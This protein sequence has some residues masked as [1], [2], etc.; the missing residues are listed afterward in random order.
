MALLLQLFSIL[1]FQ[2]LSLTYLRTPYDD[3][4]SISLRPWKRY[5]AQVGLAGHISGFSSF[6]IFREYSF[7]FS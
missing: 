1:N 4:L 7:L 3:Y 5:P 2:L 6:L